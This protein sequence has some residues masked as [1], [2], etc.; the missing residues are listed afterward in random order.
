[1][2]VVS[3]SKIQVRR[4][5][6]NQ[7]GIPQLASGEFGWAVDAQELYIGNGSISEG[8]PRIGNTRILTQQDNIF[9]LA[10]SYEY[11]GGDLQT[12]AIAD[13][14]VLRSLQ[15][16]LD[17]RVS[18]RSFGATG[19]GTAQSDEIQNAIEQL[20]SST[21]VEPSSRLVLH[22][23][24]GIYL[25]DE[26]IQL[27]PHTTIQGS[28]V[29]A[30]IFQTSGDFAAFETIA[31]SSTSGTD[32]TFN[33]QSRYVNLRDFT[34][35]SAGHGMLITNCRNSEFFNIQIIYTGAVEDRGGVVM[36]SMGSSSGVSVNGNIFH[37]VWC[38]G[39]SYGAWAITGI[40]RNIWQHCKFT[41]TDYGVYLNS[42]EFTTE[43]ERF[44]SCEF[45]N[46]KF[47][48]IYISNGV[49]CASN[50][51][52]Y[53]DVGHN[54]GG[55]PFSPFWSDHYSNASIDDWFSSAQSMVQDIDITGKLAPFSPGGSITQH[56]FTQR[57]PAQ[58]ETGSN[59]LIKLPAEGKNGYVIEYLYRSSE[60]NASRSGE[61]KIALDTGYDNLQPISSRRNIS[62]SDEYEF[63]GDASSRE[64][65]LLTGVLM[66]D[67]N[68]GTVESLIV[69]IDNTN[70]ADQGEILFRVRSKS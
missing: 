62:V 17:D 19:D 55:V 42:A 15:D 24:P 52:Q 40:F 36:E 5:R 7:G 39:F 28:G 49:D 38:D 13:D 47:N 68:D 63:V 31:N 21:D 27:P 57:A 3:I 16:R 14:P 23:E 70:V 6:K 60:A 37:N 59:R 51:S 12:G 8:A 35:E 9:E 69:E 34:I 67:D 33:T 41:S 18:I 20:F 56:Q 44:N 30:T 45:S 26:T 11:A 2:A 32:P 66:D 29:A 65:I 22:F 4:G 61:L 53:T 48:G 46:I 54:D 1:M 25:L 10:G 64:S 58:P 50:G 43:N